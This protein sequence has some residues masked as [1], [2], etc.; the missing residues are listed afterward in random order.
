MTWNWWSNR[1]ALYLWG[2]EAGV[3]LNGLFNASRWM[4]ARA[5]EDEGR[6]SGRRR[7]GDG[8]GDG[9][10]KKGSSISNRDGQRRCGTKHSIDQIWRILHTAN[11]CLQPRVEHE[12]GEADNMH[13]NIYTECPPHLTPKLKVPCFA[14]RNNRPSRI[15][16][17]GILQFF[18]LIS[19][20]PPA[21]ELK[22]CVPSQPLPGLSFHPHPQAHRQKLTTVSPAQSRI[23]H[24]HSSKFDHNHIHRRSRHNVSRQPRERLLAPSECYQSS[25]RYNISALHGTNPLP[26]ARPS[27]PRLH[28][29]R[30]TRFCQRARYR[31]HPHHPRKCCDTAPLARSQ[32]L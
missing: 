8:D 1:H 17:V 25:A 15:H 5:K 2:R 26:R 16:H 11:C 32:I 21:A 19:P 23:H 13:S 27:R 22:P 30:H 14:F 28:L 3:G 29:L 18:I 12:D 31:I 7:H 24:L 9:A 4:D 6:G 20:G 10:S